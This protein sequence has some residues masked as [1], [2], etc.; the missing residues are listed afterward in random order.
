MYRWG[1]M[2]MVATNAWVPWFHTGSSGT[3]CISAAFS[4]QVLLPD[5]LSGIPWLQACNVPLLLMRA[6]AACV[7]A[8]TRTGPSIKHQPHAPAQ[9]A[10]LHQKC[11]AFYL[12]A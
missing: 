12:L 9:Y 2:R 5:R 8:A 1:A 3:C 6:H 10:L 7:I 11:A 4:M